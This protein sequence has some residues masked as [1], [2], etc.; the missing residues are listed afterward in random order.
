VQC[1]VTGGAGFIGSNLVDALLCRGHQ[2]TVY[3][4]FSTGHRQFLRSARSSS[5]LKVVEADVLDFD[6]LRAAM[7]GHEVVVH[8]AANAD[9]RH[10]VTYPRRDVEQNTLATHNVLEAMR[11][12]GVP[13]IVFASTGSLYGE[14]TIH[15]TPEDCPFP[16]QTSL[17]GASK[18]AAEGLISA[19]SSAFGIQASIFRL[20]S[21]LGERYTH[22]HVFDFYSK[23]LVNPEIVEVLGNG[24]QRKSY[25][26]VMDCVAAMLLVLDRVSSPLSIFNLG[27][28]EFCTVDESLAWICAELGLTPRRVY[29]GGER[30]WVG[31][32]PFIFLDCARLQALG[33]RPTRSIADGVV[34][35]VR[36]LRHT[37]WLLDWRQGLPV[38]ERSAV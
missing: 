20:V 21:I 17:Y 35:T 36:Y 15:P 19:Y 33:W 28:N 2:V 31:D 26:Y 1:L 24:R 23:L 14:P 37:P 3:D 11:L 4:N 9:V 38:H 6:A 25:L 16:I 13:R 29:T 10:G 32:S 34:R 18:L 22:G 7:P 5:H 12:T 30:G 27:S 8:L